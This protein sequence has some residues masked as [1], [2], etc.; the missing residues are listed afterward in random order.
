[1]RKRF[2]AAGILLFVPLLA[3]VL[4]SADWTLT[5]QEP[6]EPKDL[7]G[8]KGQHA[9][10]P[11]ANVS[12]SRV[13]AVT[14]YPGSALVSREVDVPAGKGV[15]ELTVGPLPPTIIPSSLY[16]EAG[17]GLSVLTTRYRSRPVQKDTRADVAK[18]QAEL[19]QL[20]T[21]R[22]GSREDPPY[23]GRE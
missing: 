14:V 6:K 18:I 5:A 22:P 16:S 11:A 2:F 19:A 21:E 10:E 4:M 12:P 9:P 15:V 1:M 3:A 7:K 8:T 13:A 23:P 17:E 20:A